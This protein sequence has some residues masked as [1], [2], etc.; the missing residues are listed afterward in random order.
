M[1]YLIA[2]IA[3]LFVNA[4]MFS[5]TPDA[6]ALF[7]AFSQTDQDHQHREFAAYG[8]RTPSQ[9]YL[10]DTLLPLTAAQYKKSPNPVLHI[11]LL[12]LQANAASN[13]RNFNTTLGVRPESV[14]LTDEAIKVC[15]L[16]G[17][18]LLLAETWFDMAELYNLYGR[19]EDYLTMLTRAFEVA[20][21]VGEEAFTESMLFDKLA[22]MCKAAYRIHSYHESI[23][24]GFGALARLQKLNTRPLPESEIFLY[25]LIGSAYKLLQQPDSSILFYKKLQAVL[26]ATDTSKP[27]Y[28]LWSGIANG[29][30]G[31]CLAMK[32]DHS[33]AE[34]LLMHWLQAG[35]DFADSANIG[36]ACNALAINFH[37]KGD[38]RNALRY[39]RKALDW[40]KNRNRFEYAGKAAE[41]MAEIFRTTG[42]TDSAFYFLKQSKLYSDSLKSFINRSGLQAVQSRVKLD[43]L[44]HSLESSMALLH[45]EKRN[46]HLVLAGIV[47]LAIIVALLYNRQRLKTQNKLQRL[48]QLKREAELD[49]LKAREEIGNFV[50]HIKEKNELIDTLREKLSVDD[51][52]KARQEI[53]EKLTEYTL[54]TDSEWEQFKARFAKTYP[55][56]FPAMATRLNQV[57]PAEERLATL[58]FLGFNN[59]QIA[60]T[61]G[62]SRESVTRAKHRLKQ[63]L[64]LAKNDEL[65]SMIVSW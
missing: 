14:A 11:H 16:E 12:R 17:N 63:R 55:S 56:F 7:H 19:Y 52:V 50:R 6:G 30:I 61:L 64:G 24:L 45:E 21:R 27:F 33:A 46:K 36:L 9:E 8:Y 10:F 2:F 53:H 57:T 42:H 13:Y 51:G 62:I 60:N 47:L 59:L 29:N 18:D 54:I 20:E 65:E 4:K 34:P 28:R 40:S 1:K 32:G 39:W 58:I 43:G 22:G 5:Q 15:Y 41:G 35:L 49:S 26:A 48:A 44:Q 31:E 25:D 37:G 23:R 3:V 38:D